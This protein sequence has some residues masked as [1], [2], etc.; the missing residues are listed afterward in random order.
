MSVTSDGRQALL[1]GRTQY[2]ELLN[3]GSGNVEHS[4]GWQFS[5]ILDTA[6]TP[7]GRRGLVGTWSVGKENLHLTKAR[8]AG[9]LWFFDIT[10]RKSLFPM[11]QPYDNNVTSVAISADGRRGLSGGRRGQLTLWDLTTGQSL[12]SLGPQQGEVSP[13]AMVFLPDGHRAA[14]AGHDKLVHIWDLDT[15]R[16][17]AAWPGH[18]QTISGLAL[19]PDGRR[20]V[21]GSFDATVILWDVG[22]G[23]ILHGFAMPPDDKGAR[24]AFDPD[25]NIVA[26]GNG[27]GGPSPRPGNLIVW[28]ADTH[29]VLRRNE[30]PFARHLAVAALPGGRVLTADDYAV[31]R[32][33]P[34]PPG[35]DASEPP[36]ELNPSRA[37]VNLLTRIQPQTHKINGDWQVRD[38][39]LL[40]PAKG[41]A[42]LQVPYS[43]PRDYRVDMGVEFVGQGASA[44]MGL[45]F[46][47]SG[48]PTEILIDRTLSP[49]GR[50]HKSLEPDGR[51][52]AL[53]GYN[54]VPAPFG[55][56]P[57]HGQLLLP[58]R[59]VRL[60]L[61]V[62]STSIRLTCDGSSVVEWDGDPKRLIRN[63]GWRTS[64]PKAMFLATTGSFLI[65]E[66]TLTPLPA[67]SP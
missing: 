10:T 39:A 51:F 38:G 24:V 58:S 56:N 53:N 12:R 18:D 47:V 32:W 33:T 44:T 40:S 21:T 30:R 5:S 20:M 41:W 23:A 8:P 59:P 35:S 34:R 31:R 60:S 45:G 13:H 55:P 37:S 66:I 6:I 49:N 9:T 2:T 25:G 57:H 15:G 29:A 46:A 42:R 50:M 14:T 7:D 27:I 67:G 54:G 4:F 52:T 63:L 17:L 43:L 19:S 48:R 1:G 11:Q 64:D 28:D 16:E 3:V 62:R 22:R 26:A 61:T 65:R 36:A